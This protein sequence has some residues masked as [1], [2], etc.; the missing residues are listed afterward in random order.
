ML[1][2]TYASIN[3]ENVIK[4]RVIL[5]CITK[6]FGNSNGISNIH[7]NDIIKLCSNNIGNK[8]L[9]PNKNLKVFIKNRKIYFCTKFE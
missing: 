1:P 5:Y 4:S 8:Y 3:E 2:L 9:C 7:I 6:L